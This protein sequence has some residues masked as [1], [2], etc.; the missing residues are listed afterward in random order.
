MDQSSIVSFA[1]GYVA[2]LVV[3]F[4]LFLPGFVLFIAL[5]LV[6]GAVRLL[7][8]LLT[9]LSVGMFRQLRRSRDQDTRP[10][11]RRRSASE[12]LPH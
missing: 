10:R 6:A 9:V 12:L 5:L 4:L 3:V 2:T 8:S 1:L 11:R 7:I